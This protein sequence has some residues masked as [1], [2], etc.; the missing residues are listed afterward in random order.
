ML[1]IRVI[2]LAELGRSAEAGAALARARSFHPTDP[3]MREA[4]AQ[5]LSEAEAAVARQ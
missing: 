3:D 5:L 1:P 2:A 4:A